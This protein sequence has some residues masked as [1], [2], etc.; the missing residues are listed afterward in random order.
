VIQSKDFVQTG[1][2][3]MISSP[4]LARM[5]DFGDR[6]RFFLLIRSALDEDYSVFSC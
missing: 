1:L 6:E 3:T 5:L 2:I 4:F